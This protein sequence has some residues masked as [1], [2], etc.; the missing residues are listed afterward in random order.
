M[1]CFQ[2]VGK[3]KLEDTKGI[4]KSRKLMKD[5]Q[6]KGQ[7]KKNKMTINDLSI[8]EKTKDGTT[9]TLKI[10]G[11][12]SGAPDGLA[13]PALHVTTAMPLLRSFFHLCKIV[14]KCDSRIIKK[15][16]LYNPTKIMVKF[17]EGY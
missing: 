7:K 5:R 15:N 12:D 11:V 10:R 16:V 14:N 1:S 8:I 4:I 9:G 2:H 17:A 13:V 6:S 3:T